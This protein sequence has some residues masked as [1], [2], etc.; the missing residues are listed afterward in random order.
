[1]TKITISSL[2]NI[3]N[4]TC[5]ESVA[6]LEGLRKSLF[7]KSKGELINPDKVEFR[8]AETELNKDQ[9]MVEFIP[10]YIICVSGI[11]KK[12]N[13]GTDINC[14]MISNG[15]IISSN[16]IGKDL[17]SINIEEHEEFIEENFEVLSKALEE[18][19]I[20]KKYVSLNSCNMWQST[21]SR[22]YKR[23]RTLQVKG[24]DVNDIYQLDIIGSQIILKN[25]LFCF[26]Y[27]VYK[28]ILSKSNSSVYEFIEK[29]VSEDELETMKNNLFDN[30]YLEVND[31]PQFWKTLVQKSQFQLKRKK[32]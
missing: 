14:K 12:F 2:I 18:A 32:Q 20:N 4:E 1:M 8:I 17:G 16:I 10:S 5:S 22:F 21:L 7:I 30:L 24:F 3:M 11:E 26:Y 27:D 28:R 25:H 19:N 15:K 9:T 6:V 29:E 31:L 13:N 23:P